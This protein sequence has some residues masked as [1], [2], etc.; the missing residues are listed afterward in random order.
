MYA[1]YKNSI[2]NLLTN[3]LQQKDPDNAA[4]P[5]LISQELSALLAEKDKEIS[6]LVHASME[7]AFEQ[8]QL[9]SNLQDVR[10]VLGAEEEGE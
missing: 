2:S 5:S 8:E 1:Y 6:I 7:N 9:L 4:A 10:W 3:R